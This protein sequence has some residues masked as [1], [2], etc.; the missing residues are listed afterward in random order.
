MQNK[1]LIAI[2]ENSNPRCL[3][4]SKDG[5]KKGQVWLSGVPDSIAVITCVNNNL[6]GI[7]LIFQQ[8]VC[9][10][11]T[12]K[13]QVV[14]A[15]V[16]HDDCMGLVCFDNLLIANCANDGLIYIAKSGKIVK[17]NK[18]IK[19]ELYCHVDTQGN[20]YSVYRNTNNIHVNNLI[21]NKRYIYFMEEIIDPAGLTTDRDNNLFVACMEMDMIFVNHSLHSPAK[22]VLD[23]PDGIKGPSSI[24]YDKENDELLVVNNHSRS[25]LIFKKK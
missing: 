14:K 11:D 21:N 20:L 16:V 24:D 7:T 13:M 22:T 15:I 2:A 5:E 3:V 8:K 6:I 18:Y 23:R 12:N 10:V 19:G 25:I 17:E 4:Y 1:N 9:V